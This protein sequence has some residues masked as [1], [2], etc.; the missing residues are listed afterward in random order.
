MSGAIGV[1]LGE[2]CSRSKFGGVHFDLEGSDR[3]GHL[4]NGSLSEHSFEVVEGI[5]AFFCPLK[6]LI[7]SE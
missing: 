6:F 2:Y 3:F 4:Q 5:L 7:L 1:F